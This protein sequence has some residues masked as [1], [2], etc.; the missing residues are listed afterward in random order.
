MTRH[1]RF[2]NVL[3]LTISLSY[4]GLYKMG[5]ALD[6]PFTYFYKIDLG[7]GLN[8]SELTFFSLSTHLKCELVKISVVFTL[9]SSYR[10]RLATTPF[11]ALGI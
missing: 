11:Q 1:L 5:Q 10:P 7:P 8:L 2:H 6:H 3:S 4:S 9:L